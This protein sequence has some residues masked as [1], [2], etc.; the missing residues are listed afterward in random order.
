MYQER[1]HGLLTNIPT[2]GQGLLTGSIHCR[3]PST[4]NC[5]S[6]HIPLGSLHCPSF[7]FSAS[8]Q[9]QVFYSIRP[10]TPLRLFLISLFSALY[11]GSWLSSTSSQA[12]Q[13]TK[14][15]CFY[16]LHSTTHHTHFRRHR[17]HKSSNFYPH[18]HREASL[19][20]FVSLGF[21]RKT[22]R[23]PY[24]FPKRSIPYFDLNP[25]LVRYKPYV[26]SALGSY[27]SDPRSSGSCIHYLSS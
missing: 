2:P 7:T 22:L 26:L 6:S 19:S 1:W 25:L 23:I 21:P 24:I 9:S 10:V 15:V 14:R 5:I 17:A 4:Y 3:L 16:T 11:T 8:S 18:P 12:A 20:N 13:I 27:T